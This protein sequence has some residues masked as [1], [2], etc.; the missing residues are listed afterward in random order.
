MKKYKAAAWVLAVL[1]GCLSAVAVSAAGGLQ[2]TMG[3]SPYVSFSPDGQAWTTNAGDKDIRWYKNGETVKTGMTSTLRTPGEGEHYYYR[4]LDG[5]AVVGS[6]VVEYEAG[7]CIH[8]H[9][10]P[11]SQAGYH[12]ISYGQNICEARHYSGWRAYCADCGE[13]LSNILVYMSREAAETIHYIPMG[14]D[15]YSLCPFCA[16]LEQ[17]CTFRHTCK[18]VSANMYRVVYDPNFPPDA[19]NVGGYMS[20]S[21]HMYQDAEEYEG[22]SVTPVRE[23]TQNAYQ[24]TGY[25]F[26]GWNRQPDG[27]GDTYGDRARI[28]NLT[29]ENWSGLPGRT[30]PGTVILYAQ[31]EPVESI[32]RIDP[33]GGAYEGRS[34]VTEI[35]GRYGENYVPDAAQLKPPEGYQVSFQVNGG[36]AVRSVTAPRYFREWALVQPFSG[37]LKNGIYRYTAP[38]GSIDTLQAV[39]ET[40]GIILPQTRRDGYSF[41]GWYYDRELLL[42]AGGEG[43]TITPS[44]DLV[45]YAQWVDLELEAADNYSAY[46]GSG[47]VNLSWRMEDGKDKSYLIY[48]SADGE[49]WVKISE[50]D[51]VGSETDVDRKFIKTGG[52][53]SYVIPYTGIYT[54]TLSGAQGGGFQN[55]EG[56]RGGS[57]ELKAWLEKDEVLTFEVGGCDGYNGGGSGS[58]YGNGGGCT[59]LSSDKKGVIAVAGGGGG[60]S[61]S[62]DGNGGGSTASLIRTGYAGGDGMAGGGGGFQGG[63]AGEYILHTHEPICYT[64]TSGALSPGY[65]FYRVNSPQYSSI[66]GS[67]VTVSGT[68]VNAGGHSYD[69]QPVVRLT[70]GNKNSFLE[71]PYAGTLTFMDGETEQDVWGAGAD[72]AETSAT[73]FFIHEDGRITSETVVPDRLVHTVAVNKDIWYRDGAYEA[74]RS[75]YTYTISQK[76]FSG[77]IVRKPHAACQHPTGTYQGIHESYI[78]RGTYSFEI[79][80]DVK[81]IYIETTRRT[82]TKEGGCWINAGVRNVTYRYC[83]RTLK[84]GY[85]E[86]QIEAAQPAYGG[87]SYVNPDAVLDYTMNAGEHE[88]DGCACLK[89]VQTGFQEEL[90]L[91]N[92]KAAD[93][94]APRAV[95]ADSIARIPAGDGTASISWEE[96]EDGGTAYYH[97]A[98][99][100]LKGNT[101]R[102]CVSNITKNTLISGVAGYRYTIDGKE[103]SAADESGCYTAVRRLEIPTGGGVRYL[104]LAAV[105]AAGNMGETIH[106]RIDAGEI[107]WE[108]ITGR[109][110]LGEGENVCRAGEK[111]YYVRCDGATPFLLKHYA[112]MNGPA[113]QGNRLRY[114]IFEEGSRGQSIIYTPPGEKPEEILYFTEGT[115]ALTRYP[116]ITAKRTEEG[117]SLNVA[118]MFT[119]GM[120]A[121]GQAVELIPRAGAVLTESGLQKKYYSRREADAL[122]GIIL[123]GDGEGPVISGLDA[124]SEGR[125]IHREEEAIRLQLT[126]ADLLSGV[127]D[128]YVTVTNRDNFSTETFY[129]EN[130]VIDLEITSTKALFTGEF[131]VDVYA[132]DRVG[133]VTREC[134]TVT[135][136]ALETRIERILAPHDPV[137]KCGESGML[138]I[139]VYGYA[140]RV[141]IEFPPEFTA[142]DESLKRMVLDFGDAP[143]YRQESAVQ[144]MVPLYIPW[145][146]E[147]LCKVRACRGDKSL[148]STSV[149]YVTSEGGDVLSEFRTRLR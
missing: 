70:I 68:G 142:A 90:T 136:F 23:L 61:E 102:L 34:G 109:L 126:A 149:L 46:G 111:T 79:P 124:L 127:K 45:L 83:G 100:Y 135:E 3:N 60:A 89:S 75:V 120:E 31:W 108:I 94:A 50:A 122:N 13:A 58:I 84:C 67:G 85:E 29:S 146:R 97:M 87:S 137:F 22:A 101:S 51:D 93:M 132:W 131:T 48:Q 147:Y 36:T 96:P 24:C 43:D 64:E 118:Q 139:T 65:D 125:L 128:F 123:M 77:T 110:E 104:H 73:V 30:E 10:P 133:N 129:P 114:S 35:L 55:Y 138:Y 7:Q 12:G 4:G 134:R 54:I 76:Q 143:K 88:G 69:S 121:H 52:A 17:G 19:E 106:V 47:A 103:D 59:V 66:Y 148:E 27:S 57:I 144:F 28:Q 86:G 32:L 37:F 99:A 39:Y 14:M 15:Y 20:Y 117:R 25:R 145:G 9:Y 130:G 38:Q 2:Q 105:D 11:D 5:F 63:T 56:G 42:P 95:A 6:W 116:S 18:A 44:E 78:M 74:E 107:P 41:G 112:R 16:N 72:G 40:G 98:E 119:L 71:T 140:E 80:E 113:A 21:L 8:S 115:P 92:V 26:V 91:K 1:L 53:E 141:E 33:A 82:S 49:K 62:G 81:G